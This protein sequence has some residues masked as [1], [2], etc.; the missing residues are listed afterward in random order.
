MFYEWLFE[1]KKFSGLSRNGPLV[2][3]RVSLRMSK[4]AKVQLG[5]SKDAKVPLGMSM[6]A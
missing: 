1:P 2:T 3:I 6:D 5:M 4:D